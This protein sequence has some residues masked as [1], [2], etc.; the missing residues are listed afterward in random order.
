MCIRDS[1]DVLGFLR[2]KKDA[3]AGPEGIPYSGWAASSIECKEILYQAHLKSMS[4]HLSPWGFQPW[5]DGF[6]DQKSR[7]RLP[8][9]GAET[10]AAGTR[11]LFLGNTNNNTFASM[12]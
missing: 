4:G 3:S 1:S 8:K 7:G 12:L 5:G 11:P 10:K 6:P 9:G 2:R